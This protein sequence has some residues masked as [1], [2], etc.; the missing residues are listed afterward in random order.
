M[1]S[2]TYVQ[3]INTG[4]KRIS[5]HPNVLLPGQADKTSR[6][7]KD[8]TDLGELSD[9]QVEKLRVRINNAL[10]VYA[11]TA[12]LA[13][14]LLQVY[15]F[16]LC[17]AGDFFPWLEENKYRHACKIVASNGKKP[18][19]M[20]P[21]NPLWALYL[22]KFL[23]L[24]FPSVD[25]AMLAN[26]IVT[27]L[28]IEIETSFKNYLE[29]AVPSLVKRFFQKG[30]GFSPRLA[31]TATD[32]ICKHPVRVSSMDV[33][34]MEESRLFGVID[35]FE[36]ALTLHHEGDY[37]IS[38]KAR[39]ER[40]AKAAARTTA[41]AKAGEEKEIKRR[42]KNDDRAARGLAPLPVLPDPV[43]VPTVATFVYNRL[44]ILYTVITWT[45]ELNV[46]RER[47]LKL[48]RIFPLRDARIQFMRVDAND[49]NQWGYSDAQF[50]T[51][52]RAML[53]KAALR[54]LRVLGPGVYTPPASFQTDGVRVCTT[55]KINQ[56]VST[57]VKD[58]RI[59][60]KRRRDEEEKLQ[61]LPKKGVY[62]KTDVDPRVL[63]ALHATGA[64]FEAF[65]PGRKAPFTGSRG[66][67]LSDS[68]YVRWIH[69]D[70][71]NRKYA[72]LNG[73]MGPEPVEISGK[74]ADMEDMLS[75]LRFRVMTWIPRWAHYTQHVY[76]KLRFTSSILTHRALDLGAN[77]L[78]GPQGKKVAVIGAAGFSSMAPTTR[79]KNHAGRKGIV[80]TDDEYMT[81]Q[82]CFD[83]KLNDEVMV[84]P[85]QRH[86]AANCHCGYRW[87]AQDFSLF[88]QGRPPEDD[89]D[90][91][92]ADCRGARTVYSLFFCKRCSR[93]NYRDV[94]AALNIECAYRYG[95]QNLF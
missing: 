31:S 7:E 49:F 90:S 18:P 87:D 1:A 30:H 61:S 23:P 50:G 27:A 64:S 5:T 19:G 9:Q 76:A 84:H 78:V 26:N 93:L 89:Y 69:R 28:A 2:H 14:L 21:E 32:V 58:S 8:A 52:V 11:Q 6:K 74:V 22:Q 86:C 88:G 38:P 55:V 3:G 63:A 25:H 29:L 15:L 54:R 13:C 65:D 37:P 62:V 57:T 16:E 79:L 51:F 75:Y 68:E 39:R 72:H 42:K 59:N 70:K 12:V 33:P 47:P 92:P 80:I 83:C 82:K 17:E 24:G 91:L 40:D 94:N 60:A 81:S 41:R 66:S 77:R 53:P 36:G 35:A 95:L 10:P 44:E 71:F 46:G 73:A 48:P 4:F 45:N 34:S 43:D 20:E 85:R 56:A 67:Y